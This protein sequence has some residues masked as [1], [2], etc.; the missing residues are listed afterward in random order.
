MVR[1]QIQLTEAQAEGLKELAARS[2]VSVAELVRRGVDQL[3]S[4]DY[5]LDPQERKRR[6][7]LAVGKHGSG[8]DD[9]SRRHDEHLA[10]AF[11]R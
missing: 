3:L 7:L 1:T 5:G 11:R 8:S 9:G 4:A 10:A 2:G 6:A